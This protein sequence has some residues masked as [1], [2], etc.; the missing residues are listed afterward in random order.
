MQ[1]TIERYGMGIVIGAVVTVALLYLMQAV[2]SSDKNPLN[3]ANNIRP[4]DFVRLIDDVPP[5]L[6]DRK[7]EPPPPPDQVPPD[8]LQPDLSQDSGSTWGSDFDVTSVQP[9]TTMDMSGFNQDGEYLPLRKVQPIY[10]NRALQ[11]G[12]E[13]YVILRFTVTETGSVKDPVVVEADPPGIFDR[14]AIQAALKFKYRPRVIDGSPIEV[15]GVLHRIGFEID[16]E[17]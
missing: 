3:E 16:D 1:K 4:V 5:E 2:I 12:I 13:G 10:P 11:R 14:A 8:I 15:E 6:I 9:D 17:D 7:P